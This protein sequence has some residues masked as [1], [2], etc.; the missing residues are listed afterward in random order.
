[1]W[2][3][4]VPYDVDFVSAWPPCAP[5]VANVGQRTRG[6]DIEFVSEEVGGAR[7]LSFWR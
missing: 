2:L 6:K 5:L 4:Q 7:R 1:M 3:H